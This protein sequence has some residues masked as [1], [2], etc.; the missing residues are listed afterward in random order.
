MHILRILICKTILICTILSVQ[1]QGGCIGCT[2]QPCFCEGEKGLTGER[3][4]RGQSGA[5]GFPGTFKTLSD[6]VIS[7]GAIF[8]QN[9]E[10]LLET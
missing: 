9:C 3:G 7:F 4:I 8:E 10:F 6:E 2:V 5:E 1:Q